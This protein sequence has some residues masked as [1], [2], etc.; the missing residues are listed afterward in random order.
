MHFSSMPQLFWTK[1]LWDLTYKLHFQE[2]KDLT[3]ECI[4]INRLVPMEL[5]I[6]Y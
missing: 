3:K 2:H 1:H 6:F 5:M 4:M